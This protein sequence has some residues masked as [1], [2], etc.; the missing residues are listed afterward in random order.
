MQMI[1]GVL[2]VVGL[3]LTIVPAFFVFTGVLDIAAHRQF[4]FVGMVLWFL[5][6]PFWMRDKKAK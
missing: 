1:I 5:C 4:M 6:A 3:A 2:S